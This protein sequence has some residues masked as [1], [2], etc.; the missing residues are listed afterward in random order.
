LVHRLG[1]ADYGLWVL[2]ASVVSYGSLADL[3]FANAVTKYVAELR[4]RNEFDRAETV[5]SSALVALSAL[6]VSVAVLAVAVAGLAP[7]VFNLEPGQQ[8]TARLLLLLLGANAAIRLPAMVLLA[9]LRGLQ[10]YDLINVV[11]S[12]ATVVNAVGMVAVLLAGFG[13][14]GL[15]A[16]AIPIQVM[17][18]VPMVVA[19][20]RSEPRLRLTV[21]GAK[22]RE[23]RHLMGFGLTQFAITVNGVVQLQSD[24]IVIGA[25]LPVESITAFALARR[26]S[27]MPRTVVNQFVQ[28]LMPAASHLEAQ[29]R[30]TRLRETYLDATR[31]ILAS[32]LA[33][34]AVIVALSH[35]LLS[36]WVGARY[37]DDSTLVPILAA[38]VFLS[39]L[40]LPSMAILLGMA[41]H[42][43]LAMLSASNSIVNLSVSIALVRPFGVTG[44]ALGTLVA[45]AAEAV[46]ALPY[47]WAVLGVRR[48]Q[49]LSRTFAP[50]LLPL[51]PA[52][53][54]LYGLPA[55][56]S[57]AALGDV[58]VAG[59]CG[60][61]VYTATYLFIPVCRIE[62]GWVRAA[63]AGALRLISPRGSRARES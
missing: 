51:L 10:R 44:V 50:V 63:S 28:V 57:F 61:G 54:V 20:R 58:L 59:S 17:M 6:G 21:R 12:I 49:V 46:V 18:Q 31:I 45:T 60:A 62:R 15:A 29:G 30:L 36:V 33:V 41:R 19:I 32:F 3:G 47:A 9:I 22:W 14:V 16:I 52:F 40:M 4:A 7:H 42:R 26:L 24:Q 38:A 39:V 56:T 23:A 5:I 2:V 53:A 27:E 11:S 37:A 48:K 43:V 8:S 13:L 34:A 1:A 55:V 25:F 35:S